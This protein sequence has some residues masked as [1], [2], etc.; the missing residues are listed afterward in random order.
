MPRVIRTDRIVTVIFIL[1]GSRVLRQ[2]MI[3]AL[4][5]GAVGCTVTCTP[6]HFGPGTRFAAVTMHPIYTTFLHMSSKD[7]GPNVPLRVDM[8]GTSDARPGTISAHEEKYRP[9]AFTA[10]FDLSLH[11]ELVRM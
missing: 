2:S 5:N 1:H 7:M 8:E 3:E 4:L 9:W 6:I 11:T 10:T